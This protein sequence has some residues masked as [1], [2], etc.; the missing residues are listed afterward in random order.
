MSPSGTTLNTGSPAISP[1]RRPTMRHL[2]SF[3][4]RP[5]C[6]KMPASCGAIASTN[7]YGT[8][9]EQSS[10]YAITWPGTSFSRPG[11]RPDPT[12]CA[13]SRARRAETSFK[14]SCIA[15]QKSSGAKGSPWRHPFSL[16][17]TFSPWE[18][19]RSEG[20]PYAHL[21]QGMSSGQ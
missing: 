12:A 10:M 19:S 11:N 9:M 7:R 8:D 20:L 5:A 15:T 21:N 16:E 4:M 14:V 2:D 17:P 3:R 1:A 13:C 18:S 6:E